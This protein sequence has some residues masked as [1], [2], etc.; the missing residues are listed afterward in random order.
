MSL[1]CQPV[2]YAARLDGLSVRGLRIGLLLDMRAGLPVD[3]EVRA[4]C[5]AA[6]RALANAGA[7]VEPLDSFLTPAMLDGICTFFE[8]R[9]ELDVSR[10]SAAQRAATLPFVIEWAT[11]RAS[12]F[13]GRDVMA[14]YGQVIGQRF[15]DLGVLRLSRAIELLRPAQRPWPNP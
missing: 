15:D 12:G 6:A 8:A 10:M 13:S 2:D 4:N 1:P 9:S 3:P 11:W 7:V 14:A 5:E